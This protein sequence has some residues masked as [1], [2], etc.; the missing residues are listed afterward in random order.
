MKQRRTPG[1]CWS[2][3]RHLLAGI[4]ALALIC[5]SGAL[6]AVAATPALQ[7]AE[8]AMP[9]VA[10]VDHD[11][12]YGMYSGLALLMDV[13]RPVKPNGF[14]VIYIYGS[15]WSAPTNY[16]ARPLKNSAEGLQALA[17]PLTQAGYTIFAIDHR[18]APRFHWPAEIEDVQRAVRFVRYR[19]KQYGIN[20]AR[21]GAIGYSSG[22]HLASLLGMMPGGGTGD[23]VER[24]PVEAESSRVQCVVGVATPSDLSHVGDSQEAL[25]LLSVFLGKPVAANPAASSAIYKQLDEASPMHYIKAGDAPELLIHGD[26][27][28]LV[29]YEESVAFEQALE[30]VHVPAKLITVRGG[31]HNSIIQLQS[32]EYRAQ[33]VQWMDEHLR[34]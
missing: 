25:A 24:D 15:A 17:F 28:E 4:S 14:G 11:V 22:A 2:H 12:I 26:A 16:G 33:I 34:R 1:H 18:A 29:P 32:D 6:A 9:G 27:D 5:V 3:A 8:S 30:K 7:A 23:A 31:T 10:H 21:I 19:A 20:P 13:Y